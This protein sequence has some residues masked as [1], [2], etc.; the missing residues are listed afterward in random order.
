VSVTRWKRARRAVRAAV[1]R[2]LVQL[3][4][5]LPL[6]VATAIGAALGRAGW[7]LSSRL[8]RDMRASLAVAF[9]ERSA[10]ERDAI[11][12]ASLVNL[13]RV[14]GEVITMRRW[15]ARLDDLVQVTPEAIATV[16]RA[17]A[18]GKGIVL[19]LGHIGNWELTARLSRH[20]Q[21]NAVIAKR[22]WHR[23]LDAM[24][25]RFRAESGVETLWRDDPATGRSMLRLLRQRGTLG[26]LVDQDISDVQSVFVPFFGRLAATPRAAADLALRFGATA[27]VVTCHRAGPRVRDGHRLEV[28]EVAVRDDAPDREAEVVRLTAAFAAI[29]ERAIRRHPAEWVW[30]HQRW[31]TRPPAEAEEPGRRA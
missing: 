21:P 18:R 28:E 20:V 24:S 14:A 6:P 29:Q 13:G 26:I 11:A 31:K 19:V 12:R 27:L 23:S 5:L 10:E 9:P 30:M 22:S 25:E 3:L 4:S 17:R 2:G 8:R 15:R 1:I 16:E 7:L